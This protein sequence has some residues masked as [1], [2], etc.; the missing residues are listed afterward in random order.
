MA[1][2]RAKKKPQSGRLGGEIGNKKARS[3]RAS[4]FQAR[5][6]RGRRIWALFAAEV[7]LFISGL[8]LSRHLR[9]PLPQMLATA[10][11]LV[12]SIQ[13]LLNSCCQPLPSFS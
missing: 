5:T 4:R 12:Y 3:G 13:A 7:T 6:Q 1:S 2:F 10:F 11:S 9:R 8:L